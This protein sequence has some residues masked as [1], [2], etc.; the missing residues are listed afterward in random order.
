MLSDSNNNDRRDGHAQRA[1]VMGGAGCAGCAALDT[2]LEIEL[3]HDNV[4]GSPAND[5]NANAAGQSSG[6]FDKLNK[7]DIVKKVFQ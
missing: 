3:A 7:M 1:R 5:D 6:P 2:A 4:V